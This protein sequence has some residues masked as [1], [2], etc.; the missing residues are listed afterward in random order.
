MNS[1]TE[2]MC[3]I[4]KF[5][6][7]HRI[8]RV[9]PAAREFIRNDRKNGEIGLTGRI[10]GPVRPYW[11]PAAALLLFASYFLVSARTAAK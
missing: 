6:R 4:N 11:S 8:Y 2:R 7:M 5:I 10:Y 9:F 1:E 3:N